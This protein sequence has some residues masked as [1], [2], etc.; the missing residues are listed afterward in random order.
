MSLFSSLLSDAQFPS[1]LCAS[2]ARSRIHSLDGCTIPAL[3]HASWLFREA[4]SHFYGIRFRGLSLLSDRHLFHSSATSNGV[5]GHKLLPFA[6]PVHF[7]EIGEPHSHT[8]LSFSSR[9]HHSAHH[10]HR[11]GPALDRI[12]IQF[13]WQSNAVAVMHVVQNYGTVMSS[14]IYPVGC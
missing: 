8:T 1:P 14:A 2:D 13:V 5:T 10:R 3:S 6:N 7:R 4:V 11:S 9:F 12:R